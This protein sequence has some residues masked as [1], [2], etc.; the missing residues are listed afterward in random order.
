MVNSFWRKYT[1]DEEEGDGDHN[2]M[3]D[4]DDGRP[5][6]GSGKLPDPDNGPLC[7]IYGAPDFGPESSCTPLSMYFQILDYAF[8]TLWFCTSCSL[9]LYFSLFGF[10]LFLTIYGA[11]DPEPNHRAHSFSLTTSWVSEPTSQ[12]IQ[13]RLRQLTICG[14]LIRVSSISQGNKY[15]LG[16]CMVMNYILTLR[17]SCKELPSS[18]NSIK[19]SFKLDPVGSTVRYEMMKLCTG[20]V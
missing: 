7:S 3:V 17:S 19:Q 16:V 9:I 6:Q 15:Q 20:S 2:V 8:L 14:F 12:K 1:N 4:R 10:A 18:R 5:E 13:G 11:P